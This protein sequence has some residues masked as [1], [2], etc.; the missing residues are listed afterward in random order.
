MKK[1]R[2]TFWL[3]SVSLLLLCVALCISF[4]LHI[5][6]IFSFIFMFAVLILCLGPAMYLAFFEKRIISRG[7][8]VEKKGNAKRNGF[9]ISIFTFVCP[10]ILIFQFINIISEDPI[11]F[12]IIVVIYM[13]AAIFVLIGALIYEDFKEM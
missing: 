1:S 13:I 11:N 12:I 9:I 3:Y 4:T 10:I 8:Y 2:I 7:G 5:V 6:L